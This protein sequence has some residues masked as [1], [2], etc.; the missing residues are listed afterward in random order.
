MYS[1][2]A[3]VATAKLSQDES[4]HE[5]K[6][7]FSLGSYGLMKGLYSIYPE[8]GI[9]LVDMDLFNEKLDNYIQQTFSLTINMH[10]K[11]ALEHQSSEIGSHQSDIHYVLKGIPKHA[12]YW[13]LAFSTFD[14]NKAQTNVFKVDIEGTSRSFI[15]RQKEDY[16]VTFL[17]S[18]NFI[19]QINHE[20]EG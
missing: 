7:T 1:H 2:D 18:K 8:E 14:Q 12:N 4:T 6:L 15:L 5:W 9:S 16:R 17:V 20:P 13:D 3:N 19:R 10:Y 11:I